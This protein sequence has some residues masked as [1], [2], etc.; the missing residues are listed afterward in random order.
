MAISVRAFYWPSSITRHPMPFVTD[1]EDNHGRWKH[2]YRVKTVY[3]ITQTPCSLITLRLAPD[4]QAMVRLSLPGAND[5]SLW[6][7]Y[8]RGRDLRVLPQLPR[9]EHPGTSQAVR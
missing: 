2:D 9:V 3:P 4:A 6:H 5:D 7:L 8:G 1:H